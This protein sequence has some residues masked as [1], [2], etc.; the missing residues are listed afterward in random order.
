MSPAIIRLSKK[1]ILDVNTK[2]SELVQLRRDVNENIE[3]FKKRVSNINLNWDGLHQR[4][5]NDLIGQATDYGEGTRQHLKNRLP[6]NINLTEGERTLI[7]ESSKTQIIDFSEQ[8][9]SLIMHYHLI[10]EKL[11]LLD[12]VGHCIIIAR[13]DKEDLVQSAANITSTFS[14]NLKDGYDIVEYKRIKI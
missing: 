5:K 3:H 11:T 13:G 2:H 12:A 4:Y 7:M 9:D 8:P 1:I 6:D 14:I 10:T